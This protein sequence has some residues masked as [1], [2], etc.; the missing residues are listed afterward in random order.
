MLYVQSLLRSLTYDAFTSREK[1]RAIIAAN[2]HCGRNLEVR[3]RLIDAS[4]TMFKWLL[5]I[6][7]IQNPDTTKYNDIY[8]AGV[9]YKR[10]FIAQRKTR[11]MEIVTDLTW[12]H[13]IRWKWPRSWARPVLLQIL[14]MWFL[15]NGDPFTRMHGC[16]TNTHWVSIIY[17][18]PLLRHVVF[19]A[20]PFRVID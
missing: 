1:L 3:W 14:L 12:M 16:L 6:R 18:K 20:L 19:K 11:A 4:Y 13:W 7:S 17:H 8:L 5:F 9:L 15:L 2:S 10:V